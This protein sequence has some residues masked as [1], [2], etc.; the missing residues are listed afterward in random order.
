MRNFLAVVGLALI[1][2]APAQSAVNGWTS[3]G[4]SG[5]DIRGIAYVNGS[6]VAVGVSNRRVYRTTNHGVSWTQVLSTPFG[7]TPL[8]AVNPANGNQVLVALDQ[9]YRSTDGGVT[10]SAVTGLPPF[11][12]ANGRRPEAMT[13]TRDGSAAWIGGRGGQAYRS[14]DGGLTWTLRNNGLIPQFITGDILQLEVDAVNADTVYASTA[15]G[16]YRTTNGGAN[17]VPIFLPPNQYIYI[18]P[19][20]V[21]SGL[22][23]AFHT[24][25]GTQ[26]RSTDSGLNWTPQVSTLSGPMQFAPSVGD[27]AYLMSYNGSL[28]VTAN[29][30][31]TWTALAPLPVNSS[32]V[33]AI[34]PTDGNRLLVATL[35]G[36]QAS[37]DGGATWQSRSAGLSE[38]WFMDTFARG[39]ASSALFASGIDEQTIYQR[40]ASSGTWTGIAATSAPVLGKGGETALAAAVAPSDG[41]LYIARP[42]NFGSSGDG[43]ATWQR[44]SSSDIVGKLA[45]DPANPLVIYSTDRYSRSAKSI[46]GGANWAPVGT[47]LPV[48]SGFAIDPAN[49]NSVYAIATN[50]DSQSQSPLYRSTDAGLTWN[51]T[52]WSASPLFLGNVL[53]LEPGAP[54]TIYVGLDTGLFRTTNS[55]ATWTELT[56][57]P[58]TT[59]P[60]V[61]SI[62]ID[63]QS[64]DIVYVSTT[65]TFGPMRSVDRGATW[66][67][68]P[69]AVG[70]G[71]VYIDRVAMVPGTRSLLVGLGG[72]GGMFE[73]EVAPDLRIAATGSG[74]PA[75]AAASVVL[76]VTNAGDFSA[77]AVRVTGELPAANGN[78]TTTPTGGTCAVNVRQLTCDFGTVRP[79]GTAS[80]TLAFTPS[81]PGTWQATVS[82]Y[83][84]DS[85]STSN[86]VEVIV[87]P[88][89]PPPSPPPSGG[90]GGGGGGGRV[91]YL[92]L[93]ALLTTFFISRGRRALA[94]LSFVCVS[95]QKAFIP[96][97]SRPIVS[98]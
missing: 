39:G 23:L 83:E 71:D 57:Y 81:S 29:Q 41:T 63:P 97:S 6:G 64:P 88:A 13:W 53:A 70:A 86:S 87:A 61:Y 67:P 49:S 44:R 2:L 94:A 19:S 14:V 37:A 90:G 48:V 66:E 25:L 79:A 35:A 55:G 40:N 51:R 98:W 32:N 46:D 60:N 54:G 68:L 82:A 75:A 34:D 3:T 65:R 22:V 45:V 58:Q 5:A 92:L 42:G 62:A 12:Y 89:Q 1:A 38:L 28:Q 10:W 21:T 95:T 91:D 31:T 72:Y 77:T 33:I 17:W 9:L 74:S 11:I 84:P 20:R 50:N 52:P 47:G 16:P 8:L 7:V 43:G 18:A 15:T 93:A 76:T 4:P 24:N 59:S 73:M 56:P 27:R 30:G 96:V 85:A 78:Y 69:A 26:V 80:V 36:V